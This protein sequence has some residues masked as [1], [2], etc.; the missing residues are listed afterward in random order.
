[1]KGDPGPQGNHGVKGDPGP[2]GEP[3]KQGPPGEIELQDGYQFDGE[4]FDEASEGHTSG[5]MTAERKTR[6]ASYG[7]WS[8]DLESLSNE[9]LTFDG[10]HLFKITLYN[11]SSADKQ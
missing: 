8:L 6:L 9:R 5:L 10:M 2:Q 1:M 11:P 4:Y 3:R 7:T